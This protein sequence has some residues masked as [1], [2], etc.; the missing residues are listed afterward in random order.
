MRIHPEGFRILLIS[1]LILAAAGFGLYQILP[2]NWTWLAVFLPLVP[3]GLIL[4]FFR[5]PIR[6]IPENGDGLIYAP[7]DGQVVVIE[8]TTES[9]F[10]QDKRLQISIFMSIFDVHA[11]RIPI[12]GE[13]TF[14]KYHQGKYLLARH[15]KSSTD[16]ER[17][18]LVIKNDKGTILIRQIAGYVA[19]RIKTY[20]KEGQE[21]AQGAPLGFIRFGSRVDLFLPLDAKIEVK[22]GDRVK[23]NLDLIARL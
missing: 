21:V 5:N 19:R 3:L 9:E 18:T 15:P 13:L 23:G 4:N 14:F 17:T 11:N 10:F 7:A 12:A 20:L 2:A 22:I 8:E 6:L 1:L 16:N